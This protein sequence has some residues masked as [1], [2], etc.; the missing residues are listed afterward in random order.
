MKYDEL[1]KYMPTSTPDY[2]WIESDME[3]DS[4]GEWVFVDELDG[5]ILDWIEKY[6]KEKDKED[7][8]SATRITYQF[9]IDTLKEMF[10][11]K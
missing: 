10:E 1:K 5:Y 4:T 8:D 3:E 7:K 2:Y 11:L 6:E 9:L